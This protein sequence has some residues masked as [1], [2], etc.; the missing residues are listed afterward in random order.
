V[1]GHKP[2]DAV[3]RADAQACVIRN[4]DALT[5]EIIGLQNDVAAF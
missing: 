4:R 1:R 5:G 2:Q 3:P